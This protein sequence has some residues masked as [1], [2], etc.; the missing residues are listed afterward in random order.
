[1][2][3]YQNSI[4][5]CGKS[6]FD[7]T[8]DSNDVIRNL[9]HKTQMLWTQTTEKNIWENNGQINSKSKTRLTRIEVQTWLNLE[10][11]WNWIWL[12][13]W[14]WNSGNKRLEIPFY[15][16]NLNYFPQLDVFPIRFRKGN[17]I[18]EIS[19]GNPIGNRKF[20]HG[21]FSC[22]IKE[23]LYLTNKNCGSYY[24]V[25]WSN[26]MAVFFLFGQPHKN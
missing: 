3:A 21:S 14:N 16:P 24:D 20:G 2:L 17:H 26:F 8:K 22:F 5:T 13:F 10:L 11:E 23:N 12:K 15:Y 19:F 4:H 25:L 1:M 9:R 6:W 18:V 7:W